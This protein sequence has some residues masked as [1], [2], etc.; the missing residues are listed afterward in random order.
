MSNTFCLK[1]LLI[2]GIYDTLSKFLGCHTI[3]LSW[4]VQ[5]IATGVQIQS[6]HMRT[7]IGYIKIFVSNIKKGWCLK[8]REVQIV[9]MRSLV[10]LV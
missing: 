3:S 1:S 4:V 8:L 9:T 10:Q 7:V 5:S 6:L 2:S